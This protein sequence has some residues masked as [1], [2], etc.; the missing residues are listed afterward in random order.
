MVGREGFELKISLAAH[1]GNFNPEA[2]RPKD[3]IL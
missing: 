1:I 3:L 2:V